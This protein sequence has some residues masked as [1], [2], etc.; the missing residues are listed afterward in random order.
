VSDISQ[1]LSQDAAQ[2]TLDD[3]YV[4]RV[5]LTLT[6]HDLALSTARIAAMQ[7]EIITLTRLLVEAQVD[8][9]EHS[10]L[11]SECDLLGS[12]TG[13]QSQQLE[14]LGR[15]FASQTRLL[16]VAEDR[17]TRAEY[18]AQGAT[19]WL[20][21]LVGML[22]TGPDGASLPDSSLTQ[23]ARRLVDTGLFDPAWYLAANSDVKAGGI[24]PVRHFL[25]Y[26]LAEGRLPRA[27]ET[28][29]PALGKDRT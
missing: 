23:H 17:A 14:A 4:C 11:Q 28:A 8:W 15:E 10:K 5:E 9:A 27:P 16:S 13:R 26:G 25:L 21:A 12:A 2:Q 6:A 29:A 24:D 18:E 19:G 3:L 1:T 20:R 22:L 7:R